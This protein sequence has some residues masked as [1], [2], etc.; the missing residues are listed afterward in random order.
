MAEERT[1]VGRVTYVPLELTASFPLP[2]RRWIL[3]P[4]LWLARLVGPLKRQLDSEMA[5]VIPRPSVRANYTI[6]VSSTEYDEYIRRSLAESGKPILSSP[7]DFDHVAFDAP[8]T[9][10]MLLTAMLLQREIRFAI[11]GAYGFALLP[12]GRLDL[13]DRSVDTHLPD[14]MPQIW[15]RYHP[16]RSKQPL[17]RRLLSQTIRYLEPHYRPLTWEINRLSVALRHFWDAFTTNRPHQ[18]FMSLTVL[19][20]SLLTTQNTE[21]THR[22]AE[23]VASLVGRDGR[24]RLQI[25]QD[26]RDIY[27]VRSKIAHGRG[28]PKHGPVNLKRAFIISTKLNFV[29]NDVH[30]KLFDLSIK[31]L[32]ALLMNE[33]YKEIVR[34]DKSDDTIGK[35]LD[36]FFVKLLLLK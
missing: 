9:A 10:Q 29:P 30:R 26:V 35:N 27:D 28:V 20:E 24:D 31:L 21:L 8:S 13:H 3:S 22:I 18:N 19:L 15:R 12:D 2:R 17:N 4:G 23:R 32:N 11:G 33:E 1:K 7:K 6:G 34:S 25:Y 36:K 5:R 16:N 14:S